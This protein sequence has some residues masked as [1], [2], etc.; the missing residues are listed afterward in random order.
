LIEP[1]VRGHHGPYLQWI[2][3]GLIE[4]G[5]S[6]IILTLL[7]SI[8]HPSLR[9][10]STDFA[11]VV[12]IV[13]LNNGV[14]KKNKFI[15]GILGLVWSEFTYWWMFRKWHRQQASKSNLSAVFLPYL[16]YCLYL[17]GFLGSPFGR[18]PWAGITMRPSFHHFEMGIPSPR[19]NLFRIKKAMFRRLLKNKGLK[20]VLTIDMSL[21]IY[22]Q[23]QNMREDKV[24][25]LPQPS[26]LIPSPTHGSSEPKK[27]RWV[28][29][30]RRSILLYGALSFRKGIKELLQAMAMPSF[31]NYV[32]VIL[33]G[34]IDKEV[35]PFLCRQ[36]VKTLIKNQRITVLDHYISE[37]EEQ[38]LFEIVDIVWLGYKGHYTSSGVLVQ[39][40][41]A[42]RPVIACEEGLIGWQTSHYD[43]G[44]VVRPTDTDALVNGIQML[45]NDC[46]KCR[47][48]GQNGQR[49]F[50]NNNMELAEK[51]VAE[52]LETD[53]CEVA[54]C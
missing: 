6:L 14:L 28:E 13:A 45:A 32:N 38:V 36:E 51:L 34:K 1:H 48:Y 21:L 30:N 24:S 29:Q 11:G 16:D 43:L 15:P 44:I 42:G 25:F 31:P 46:D 53:S 33:A 12:D 27:D 47:S 19:P 3:Q 17:I 7:E 40:A 52:A 37:E 4:H 49:A 9:K 10:I 2:V 22:L 39:A 50:F 20:Q 35:Y 26:I 18:T 5:H 41:R 54:P 8:R 23:R